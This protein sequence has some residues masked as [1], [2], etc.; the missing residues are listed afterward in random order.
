MSVRTRGKSN[1]E[2]N[3]GNW[4][5]VHQHQLLGCC[6]CSSHW[7]ATSCANLQSTVAIASCADQQ[8]MAHT[9]VE[10]AMDK[11]VTLS[12]AVV[13]VAICTNGHDFS[14]AIKLWQKVRTK[15]SSGAHVD[16]I[17]ADIAVYD[18][19]F[20]LCGRSGNP[21]DVVRIW[22]A[23]ASLPECIMIQKM[24]PQSSQLDKHTPI[25]KHQTRWNRAPLVQTELM[26]TEPITT[27]LAVR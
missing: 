9:L 18:G 6:L 13:N 16:E 20:T 10:Q 21:G 7:S 3:E 19:L 14:F 2:T 24:S 12:P 17:L 11:Y 15:A 23:F 5:M 22:P 26:V 1:D 27:I 8:I 25:P 4:T